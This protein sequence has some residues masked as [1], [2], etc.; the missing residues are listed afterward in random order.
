MSVGVPVA[1]RTTA[2]PELDSEAEA[3]F[4]ALSGSLVAK[5]RTE[6]VKP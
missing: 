3:K 4:K 2:P 1:R 5:Y 6:F